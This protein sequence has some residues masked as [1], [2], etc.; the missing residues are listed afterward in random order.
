M[1]IVCEKCG[2]AYGIADE[3]IPA[4]GV[5][6]QCPRCKALQF[7]SKGPS[8]GASAA[9]PRAAP[10][11]SPA[12]LP[13]PASGVP[14]CRAC[15]KPLTDAI[16][17]AFGTCAACMAKESA[18]SRPSIASPEAA[19]ADRDTS[20]FDMDIVGSAAGSAPAFPEVVERDAR[21]APTDLDSLV[22]KGSAG[23]QTSPTAS[24]GEPGLDPGTEMLS[25]GD[26]ATGQAADPAKLNLPLPPLAKLRISASR[27]T[28]PGGSKRLWLALGGVLVLV[29][30]VGGGGAGY[31]LW[32]KKKKA[33]PGAGVGILNPTG[34]KLPPEIEVVAKRW[35]GRLGE[36]LET[37]EALATRLQALRAK[38]EPEAYR[39]AEELYRKAIVLDP[40]SDDLIAGYVDSLALGRVKRIDDATY[41]EAITLADA[42][43]TRSGG[44]FRVM[45][46][47]ANLLLTREEDEATLTEA[48]RIAE[49]AVA[50][51]TSENKAGA[52]LALGRAYVASSAKMSM[53]NFDEALRLDPGMK[54]AYFYRGKAHESA[55]ELRAAIAD[56]EKCLSLFPDHWAAAEAI[57][58]IYQEVGEPAAAAEL[59]GR[60][61]KIRPGDLRVELPLAVSKY[62]LE[63]RPADAVRLLKEMLKNKESYSNNDVVAVLT[64]LAAAQRA[65][66]NNAAA[67]K[68][69]QE[70]LKIN[71]EDPGAN[72]QLFLIE[73]ERGSA[74]DASFRLPLLK[75]QL[76]DV[77]LER[78]LEGRLRLALGEAEAA[79]DL[80][81]QAADADPK[82]GDALIMGGVA[83]A[84]CQKRDEASRLLLKA[85]QLDPA[86]LYPRPLVTRFYLKPLETLRG[87][88]GSVQKLAAGQDVVM[89]KLYEG[90][91]R[92]HQRDF[93]A[94]DRY[95]REV[96]DIDVN[97]ALAYALRALIAIEKKDRENAQK[98]AQRAIAMGR[99]APMSHYA[100]AMVYLSNNLPDQAERELKQV[101]MPSWLSVETRL[102]EM[103]ARVSVDE[104]RAQLLKLIGIDPTFY[105]AKRLLYTLEK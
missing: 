46:A 68:D 48:R 105:P 83:A 29:A 75:G 67:A 92:Y 13:K 104:A 43:E 97:N 30:A 39:E 19:R 53:K 64:H 2:A 17:V 31:W 4:K 1:R 90:L 100:Q 15:A 40:W 82:R 47:Y 85:T 25:S 35:R 32:Q 11:P 79:L 60:V 52:Y 45:A 88:E 86:R 81:R 10:Q 70:A 33:P 6:A 103:R 8:N 96:V 74:K 38:D 42:A 76:D 34:K 24:D 7:V 36:F 84:R 95:L 77:A 80:F 37:R 56:F 54:R 12:P 63:N 58:R 27:P 14:T 91:I 59:Y 73:L 69:A 89:P 71:A 94:A 23:A 55:G 93:S 101:H 98:N 62:Q 78:L 9:P 28:A 41:A 57:A 18:A 50:A 49:A 72:L 5:R 16:D 102:A 44:S 65:Q 22:G 66:G 61:S 51:N 3:K 21:P 99:Q 87:A 26:L 20:A